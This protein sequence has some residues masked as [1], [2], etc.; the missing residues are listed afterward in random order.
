MRQ[1]QNKS[2]NHSGKRK[3]SVWKNGRKIIPVIDQ[4]EKVRKSPKIIMCY[5]ISVEAKT[6]FEHKIIS[7]EF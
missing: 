4:R 7:F 6:V 2:L 5:V 3:L 1:A